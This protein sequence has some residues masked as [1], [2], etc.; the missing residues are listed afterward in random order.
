MPFFDVILK[1]FKK[2]AMKTIKLLFTSI[3][4]ALF[5]SCESD[6]D[7]NTPVD[8]DSLIGT[9]EMISLN[10]DTDFSGNLLEVPITSSTTS[11]GEN[12]D[13]VLTF[14]ETTYNASGS[15]DIV[16]TGTVNGVPL[17]E[18]RETITDANESGTYEF[19]DGELIIDGALVDVEDVTSEL[20]GAEIDPNFEATLNSNGELVIEQRGEISVDVE[21]VPLDI[22]YDSRVVFRK[23]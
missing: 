22:E 11:V 18:E 8:Q 17:D 10:V 23:Q 6:D 2:N 4:L 16:T 1:R 14:T 21:G 7:T 15:Y 9:W 5:I 12:F 13:Y 20:E 19:V 3:L